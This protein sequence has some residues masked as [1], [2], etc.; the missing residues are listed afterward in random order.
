M[1][2]P[3]KFK[4]NNYYLSMTFFCLNTIEEAKKSEN[5]ISLNEYDTTI[6]YKY[7]KRRKEID[8]NMYENGSEIPIA[9]PT[10]HPILQ[11]ATYFV[12]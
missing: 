6:F 1:V 8:T 10:L 4:K 12:G 5:D 9:E 7:S 11:R 2:W 3:E